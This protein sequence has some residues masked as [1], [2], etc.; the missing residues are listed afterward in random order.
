L[1]LNEASILEDAPFNNSTDKK[2]NS[3]IKSNGGKP[4]H[5]NTLRKININNT[6]KSSS[7]TSSSVKSNRKESDRDGYKIITDSNKSNVSHDSSIGLEKFREELS[8]LGD[9]STESR[10]RCHFKQFNQYS[11]TSK[12]KK[13]KTS[14]R[15]TDRSSDE[16]GSDVKYRDY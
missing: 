10:D 3:S 4:V 12:G 11:I 13:V 2:S 14:H 5:I 15:Y 9:F 1:D 8:K 7:I 6:N 16:K